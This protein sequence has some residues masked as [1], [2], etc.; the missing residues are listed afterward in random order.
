[1]EKF[2]SPVIVTPLGRNPGRNNP[3]STVE[4]QK[5]WPH[6]HDVGPG[7]AREGI[8]GR[9]LD[10]HVDE[11]ESVTDVRSDG[12]SPPHLQRAASTPRLQ[13]LHRIGCSNRRVTGPPIRFMTPTHIMTGNQHDFYI[14]RSSIEM[15]NGSFFEYVQSMVRE[16]AK[17]RRRV[18]VATLFSDMARWETR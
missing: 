2:A 16:S 3:H 9:S 12:H 13:V 6:Q 15:A 4:S 18:R 14:L 8:G 10:T 11:S 17:Q 7:R 5:R 1:M